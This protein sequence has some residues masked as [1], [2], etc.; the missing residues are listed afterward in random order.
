MIHISTN[1]LISIFFL[2][3][4]LPFFIIRFSTGWFIS[5]LHTCISAC[6]HV[7]ACG[8]TFHEHHL[9]LHTHMHVQNIISYC[10]HVPVC[11]HSLWLYLYV[12]GKKILYDRSSISCFITPQYVRL[13]THVS[14]RCYQSSDGRFGS[15]NVF[16]RF[17]SI[18]IRFYHRNDCKFMSKCDFFLLTDRK[19]RRRKLSVG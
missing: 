4:I 5:C 9:L 14:V 8:N 15:S 13:C 3:S 11:I 19:N 1:R 17:L 16:P 6:T 10:T 12:G 18:S 2:W 7:Y